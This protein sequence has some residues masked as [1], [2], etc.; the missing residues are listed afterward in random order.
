MSN[1]HNSVQNSDN[2]KTVKEEDDN[3]A[4]LKGSDRL[5]KVVELSM[6][7]V[8]DKFFRIHLRHKKLFL[9]YVN[10]EFERKVD[11]QNCPFGWIRF[12][13]FFLIIK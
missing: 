2:Q 1:Y 8:V 12:R 7:S 6:C 9:R 5:C 13:N 11:V 4:I 3:R 10:Y